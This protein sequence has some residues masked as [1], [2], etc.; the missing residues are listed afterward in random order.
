V[1]GEI[2]PPA[3]RN[4]HARQ[5]RACRNRHDLPT[6]LNPLARCKTAAIWPPARPPPLLPP[7][8][9]WPAHVVEE[10][11]RVLGRRA[12]A[13]EGGEDH[14]TVAWVR[15][16]EERRHAAEEVRGGGGL[17]GA[18]ERGGEDVERGG[19]GGAMRAS[20]SRVPAMPPP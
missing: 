9:A 15:V 12:P 2:R 3:D 20:T 10:R 19:V 4:P 17:A 14:A 16:E 5:L 6:L 1:T 18:A 8:C 13:A 11:E 7:L